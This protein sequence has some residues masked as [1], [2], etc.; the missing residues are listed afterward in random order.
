MS[1]Y[2]PFLHSEASHPLPFY[3]I[4][5][6]FAFNL[7]WHYEL[8]EDV[9]GFMWVAL[10]ANWQGCKPIVTTKT[11]REWL[12]MGKQHMLAYIPK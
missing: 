6:I 11:P 9:L 12:C 2:V 8:H 5:T 3:P 1:K 7:S 4:G 10:C